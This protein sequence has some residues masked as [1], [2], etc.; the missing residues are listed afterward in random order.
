MSNIIQR[1][2]IFFLGVPAVAAIIILLPGFRH[3]AAVAIVLAILA[4]CS[5][6][7]AELFGNRGIR[8]GKAESLALTLI[9]PIGAYLYCLAP[10]GSSSPDGAAFALCATAAVAVFG[11]L[12]FTKADDIPHI[13]PRAAAM[14]LNMGYLGILGSF[15]VLIAAGPERSTEALLSFCLLCFANDGMAWL[16]GMTLGRKRGIVAVSPNKSLAG[17]IGGM[18]GSIIMAFA[19]KAAFPDSIDAPWWAVLILGIAIGAAVIC[20]DLFESA[21]KRSAGTKDS[22]NAVP[23]RGGFLDSFDSLLLAAPVFFALSRLM[24]LF[25]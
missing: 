9:F 22:G 21:L 18:A 23:G 8:V 4:M 16:V 1:L 14:S 13:L 15:I 3:L 10:L 24:G 7:L 2:L 19:C 11:R 20:G 5:L 12:A 25:D 17:F 6:E